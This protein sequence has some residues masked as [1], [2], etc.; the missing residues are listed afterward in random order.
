M[1]KDPK[2]KGNRRVKYRDYGF[3]KENRQ[4][5]WLYMEKEIQAARSSPEK[6]AALRRRLRKGMEWDKENKTWRLKEEK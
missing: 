3:D 6:A 2:D 1:N 4:Q 5:D